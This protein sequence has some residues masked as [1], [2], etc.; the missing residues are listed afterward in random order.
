MSKV[1]LL[2]VIL[3]E[4]IPQKGYWQ[5][6]ATGQ[7]TWVP[8]DGLASHPRGETILLVPLVRA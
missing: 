6:L 3:I 2:E 8:C 5:T 1:I 7:N 4:D